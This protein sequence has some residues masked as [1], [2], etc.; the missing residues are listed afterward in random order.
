MIKYSSI[1]QQNN[2]QPISML[3][4]CKVLIH[5]YLPQHSNNQGVTRFLI[6]N[7]SGRIAL[8]KKRQGSFIL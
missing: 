7:Y 8:D 6:N 3:Y 5:K 1:G 4:A 2:A